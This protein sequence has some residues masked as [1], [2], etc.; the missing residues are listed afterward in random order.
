[1]KTMVSRDESSQK[2]ISTAIRAV[3]VASP[4]VRYCLQ[5]SYCTS[6]RPPVLVLENKNGM[7]SGIPYWEFHGT[8][9]TGGLFGDSNELRM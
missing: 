4:L 8:K 9:N 7:S 3:F 5:I 1:M 6:F 2:C